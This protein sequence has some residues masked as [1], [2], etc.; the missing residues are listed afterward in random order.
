MSNNQQRTTQHGLLEEEKSR[1]REEFNSE[2]EK[3]SR[4]KDWREVVGV[5]E[6]KNS[7]SLGH[8]ISLFGWL[9][10]VSD[11]FYRILPLY[12]FLLWR[13]QWSVLGIVILRLQVQAHVAS[14]RASGI[15]QLSNSLCEFACC[16]DPC[17]REEL[18]GKGH[19]IFLFRKT[20]H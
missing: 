19:R 17:R 7:F 13:A 1:R 3:Q 12:I 6:E 9:L 5:K 15:K 10:G 18:K 4:A 8:V 11:E 16:S 2:Q 20:K 14:G